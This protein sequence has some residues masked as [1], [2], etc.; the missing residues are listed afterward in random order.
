MKDHKAETIAIKLV[1]DVICRHGVPRVVHTDQGRDFESNLIKQVCDLLEIE[2]TRT[3]AYHPKSYGLVERLNKTLIGMLRSCV[4]ENQ[5]KLGYSPTKDI[6]WISL[7]CA[8]YHW[9]FTV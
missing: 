1:D 5:K 2:K 8:G 6:A 3:T 7:K 4:D 9:I